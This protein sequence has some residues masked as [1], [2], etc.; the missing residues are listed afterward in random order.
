MSFDGAAVLEDRD[1]EA[2]LA[3]SGRLHVRIL[4][5]VDSRDPPER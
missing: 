4:L 5:V 1:H 3:D 2:V